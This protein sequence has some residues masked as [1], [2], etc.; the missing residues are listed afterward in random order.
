MMYRVSYQLK[1]G[2][3]TTLKCD[4]IEATSTTDA[5]SRMLLQYYKNKKLRVTA[6]NVEAVINA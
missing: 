2:S 5:K 3:S 1:D 6:I 4:M